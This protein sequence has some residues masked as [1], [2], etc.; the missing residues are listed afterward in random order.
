[1]TITVYFLLGGHP[2]ESASL[3]VLVGRILVDLRSHGYRKPMGP[4]ECHTVVHSL[5]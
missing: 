2:S 4:D 5:G 1:M 3:C